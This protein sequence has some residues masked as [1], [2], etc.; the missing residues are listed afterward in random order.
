MQRSSV[1]VLRNAPVVS[2]SSVSSMASLGITV[3]IGQIPSCVDDSM[4]TVLLEQCGKVLV[5]RRMTSPWDGT[6]K[7]F[8]F[9]Q[10]SEPNGA[11]KA[12]RLLKGIEIN[13][14]PIT[15]CVSESTSE[16]LNAYQL[17]MKRLSTLNLIDDD[18]STAIRVIHKVLGNLGNVKLPQ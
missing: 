8:G 6:P 15:V 18:D 9:C 13:G 10:Y 12:L 3:F 4:L 14:K 16:R 17:E 7:R 11:I 2:N 5:W 1:P